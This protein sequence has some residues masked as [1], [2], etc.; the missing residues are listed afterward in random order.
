M[1]YLGKACTEGKDCPAS[2]I[3]DTLK[4]VPCEEGKEPDESQLDCTTSMFY[5]VFK[6]TIKDYFNTS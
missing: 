6:T 1:T 4:C 5:H 2:Q 3:C